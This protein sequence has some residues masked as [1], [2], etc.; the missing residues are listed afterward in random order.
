MKDKKLLVALAAMIAVVAILAGV[1]YATRPEVQEGSKSFT[2]TVVHADGTTKNF[3][4][5]TDAEYLGAFLYEKGLI[6]ADEDNIG[7]FHTVDGEKADW[8]ENQS[9][10]ALYIGQDYATQGIDATPITDGT[11]YRLEYTIWQS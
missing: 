6:L 9:Y 4:Y 3:T 11:E 5:A 8:N 1:W 2:V 10:W 7:L